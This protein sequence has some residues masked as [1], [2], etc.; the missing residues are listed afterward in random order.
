MTYNPKHEGNVKE[1]PSVSYSE[2]MANDAGVLKWLERIVSLRVSTRGYI[3]TLGSMTGVSAW[4][5][6][7]QS[8]LN[9]RR[10]S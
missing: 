10:L 4:S 5:E 1:M 9:A 2:V 3:L 7:P 6:I 8:T